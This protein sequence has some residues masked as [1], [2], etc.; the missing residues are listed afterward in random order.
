VNKS[1]SVLMCLSPS[2][3]T[4]DSSFSAHF[5]LSFPA[6]F[7]MSFDDASG[8]RLQFH[9][10]FQHLA[11]FTYVGDPVFFPFREVDR[12]RKIS[13]DES[14]LVLEVNCCEIIIIIYFLFN[15]CL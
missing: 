13:S 8:R 7:E 6:H 1:A 14:H 9:D 5:P 12:L 2:L 3:N 15:L 10:D 11:N 4:L